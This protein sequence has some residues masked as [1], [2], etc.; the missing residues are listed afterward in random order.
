MENKKNNLKELLNVM[1]VLRSDKGCNWDKAQTH[2][3]LVKYL[4]EETEEVIENIENGKFDEDLKEELGDVLLQIIFHSQIAKEE[5]RFDFYD[6]I[7]FLVNKLKFRHPHVFNKE[8]YGIKG[9]MT[10]EEIKELWKVMK[11]KEKDLKK[12][13]KYKKEFVNEK[14]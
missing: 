5:G 3:T 6:V 13:K 9:D 2:E 1:E 12:N 4:R 10:P 7:D 11:Q 8:K 14:Y